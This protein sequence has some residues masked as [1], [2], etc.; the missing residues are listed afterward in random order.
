MTRTA[1]GM[2]AWREQR[3][4]RVYALQPLRDALKR[5]GR[6]QAWLIEALHERT[7]IEMTRST[8]NNYLNGYAR[9]PQKQLSALCWIAGAR[10]AE[11]T[12]RIADEETLI[13]PVRGTRSPRKPRKRTTG[14]VSGKG[15]PA[16]NV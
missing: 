15:K 10:E 16:S 7:G 9:I 6:R 8:L 4:E 13:Q 12:W 3:A 1:A 11:I 14:G 5:E 2:A